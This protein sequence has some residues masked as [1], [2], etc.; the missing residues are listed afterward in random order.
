[1]NSKIAKLIFIGFEIVRREPLQEVL[2]TLEKNQWYDI[3]TIK[4]LQWEKLKKLLYHAYENVPYYRSLF[5]NN[6]IKPQ[7]IANENDFKRIPLLTKNDFR[8]NI[9]QIYANNRDKRASLAK[10]SGSTGLSLK[11]FKG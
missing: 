5:D 8:K 11:I 6:N 7:S 3:K 1:M 4:K 9:K 10:T 2:D